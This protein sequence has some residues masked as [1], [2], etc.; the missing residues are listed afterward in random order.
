MT[1]AAR[2]YDDLARGF[3]E[4]TYANIDRVHARRVR[5]VLDL[6]TP[7]VRGDLSS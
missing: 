1:D 7:L 5:L 6:G 2:K 3:S 4:R